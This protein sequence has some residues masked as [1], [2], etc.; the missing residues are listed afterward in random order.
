MVSEEG[1]EM[2]RQ[3]EMASNCTSGSLHWMLEKVSS[4]R[5]GQ[6]FEHCTQESVGS[7]KKY[8]AVAFGNTAYR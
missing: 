1:K 5:G 3:E 2:T 8:V 7:V 4:V 6:A